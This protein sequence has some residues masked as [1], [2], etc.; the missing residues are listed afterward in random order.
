MK[1][2]WGSS[3][4]RQPQVGLPGIG[5]EEIRFKGEGEADTSSPLQDGFAAGL[6]S[7]APQ[8]QEETIKGDSGFVA[9]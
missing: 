4:R 5:L 7:F 8:F 9:G 6:V 3:G 2:N 1:I